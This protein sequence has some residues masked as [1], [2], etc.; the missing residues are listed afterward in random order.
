MQ[1]SQNKKLLIRVALL[2]GV[3]VI[4]LVTVSFLVFRSLVVFIGPDERG[5]VISPYE[6]QGYRQEVLKPGNRFIYP[7]ERVEIYNIFRQTYT[8][9]KP[10]S[11][12]ATT[13]DG[14]KI[15]VDVS[16]TYALDPNKIIEIHINWQN[17]YEKELVRPLLR[18]VIRNEISNLNSFEI[19]SQ[20]SQLEENIYKKLETEFNKNSLILLE[21]RIMSVQ[22][23]E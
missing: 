12:E 10:D 21:F 23:P 20:F 5:L 22:S 7:G 4:C 13:L 14:K 1:T 3:G 15:L 17:R 8:I 9:A 18:E 16:I 19:E 6:P 11:I 2:L